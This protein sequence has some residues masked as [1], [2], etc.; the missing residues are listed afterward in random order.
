MTKIISSVGAKGG[1][2]KSSIA[3]FTA[4]ELATSHKKKVA[5]LDA[6][7]Q[8]T[9]ISA[10]LLNQDLPFEVVS[11][12]NKTKLWETGKALADN[13]IDYIIIDGNPRSI[14]EDPDLIKMIARLSD[15][16]LI[17]TRPSPRDIKA[18]TRYV[19]MVRQETAGD[20]K[21]VWNFYQKNTGA[22]KEG[23]PEGEKLLNLSSLKTKIGNR[24]CFQDI[25]YTEDIGMLTKQASCEVKALVKEIKRLLDGKK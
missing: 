3:L 8:G 20:I 9:C 19:D 13:G 25:G 2:G 24:I 18:Q 17:I 15:L 5:V 21:L 4:W 23:V 16:S 14:N 11:V 6:D 12:G 22:H 10:K 7:I 1:T